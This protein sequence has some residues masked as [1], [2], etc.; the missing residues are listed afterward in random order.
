[1]KT[2]CAIVLLIAA[3]FLLAPLSLLLRVGWRD[4]KLPRTHPD[5][6]KL[7]L[8]KKL[9]PIVI[10]FVVSIDALLFWG[11]IHLLR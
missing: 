5:Y 11:A 7:L 6:A 4:R 9:V 2:L 3:L 10:A 1:M 8:G